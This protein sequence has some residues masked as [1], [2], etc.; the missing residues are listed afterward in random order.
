MFLH[1]DNGLNI[2]SPGRRNQVESESNECKLAYWRL[3][4]ET[5][6]NAHFC[7]CSYLHEHLA[8]TVSNLAQLSDELKKTD[9]DSIPVM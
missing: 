9:F 3:L 1:R 6:A 8:M 4:S 2:S 5:V 7:H